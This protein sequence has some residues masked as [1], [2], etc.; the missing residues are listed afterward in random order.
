MWQQGYLPVADSL[1]YSALAAALPIITMLVMI[2][3]LRKPPWAAALAGLGTALVVAIGV[4]GMPTALAISIELQ[5]QRF[6]AAAEM[7]LGQPLTVQPRLPFTGLQAF[8]P[9]TEGLRL[10]LQQITAAL[11]LLD[12]NRLR[13]RNGNGQRQKQ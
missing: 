1:A 11:Q 4:Y 3:V 6:A 5:L 10:R 9:Q 8:Y 12:A 7:L 2:G 13:R